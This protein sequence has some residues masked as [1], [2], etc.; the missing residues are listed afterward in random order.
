M[1]ENVIFCY[2][3][4]GNC[5]DM[6]KN[7][8]KVL[9]DTDIIMMRSRPTVTDVKD[10]KR[11]GFVF[12]C[13]GGGLPG[14]VEK[15]VKLVEVSPDAYTFGVCQFAG[16]P[17]NGLHMIDEIVGLDYWAMMSHQCGYIVLFPHQLMVPPMTPEAAQARSEKTA[18]KIGEDVLAGR[19]KGGRPP[20]FK[21]NELEYKG[22]PMITKLKSHNFLVD[23]AKCIGCGQCVDIC[24]NG[25]IR[26]IAGTP[27]FGS[28]CYQCV[29]CLQYCPKQAISLGGF[30]E[31]RERYHNPN[32]PAAELMKDVIHID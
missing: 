4:T 5:L 16:Y 3:G 31:K 28:N 25:N 8:A 11:V 14:D 9:G 22:W 20:L 12:P 13:Y 1:S 32:V 29:S 24:P 30:T 2:S 17:G 6:A 26:M 19:E 27:S 15:F 23:T 7:I 18:R 10:A 21:I